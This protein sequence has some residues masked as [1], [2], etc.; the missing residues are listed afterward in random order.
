MKIINNT[1]YNRDL[2]LKY[3]KFYSRSYMIKNFIIITLISFGFATYM[4]IEEQWAYAGLLIGILIL[5]YV[6]TLG[7]QKITTNR[8]LKR[9]PLV[10][11]PLLQT[12][13]FTEENFTV[14]NVN[15]SVFNY[16]VIQTIKEAPDFYMIQ[17]KDRKTYLVDYNGFEKQTDKEELARFLNLKY[18]LKL[19]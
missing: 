3:N 1:M 9:S 16:D 7:M 15:N 19:K 12:Y 17:T 4:A 14:T 2:I 13:V 18:N 10:E 6:L 11:N 5:Y 8:M